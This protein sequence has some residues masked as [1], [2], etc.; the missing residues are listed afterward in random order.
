[1][2]Q[3]LLLMLAQQEST[4][5]TQ[6]A[7]RKVALIIVILCL[8]LFGIALASANGTDKVASTWVSPTVQAFKTS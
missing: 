3:S 7:M 2:L 8:S 1:M 6:A 5:N 4:D